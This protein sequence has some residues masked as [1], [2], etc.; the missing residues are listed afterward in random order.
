L[1]VTT[2]KGKREVMQKY[3]DHAGIDPVSIYISTLWMWSM[4]Y[5]SM[6]VATS[7]VWAV[8]PQRR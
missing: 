5:I 3:K 8:W 7:I 6:T 4:V 1:D 2:Q